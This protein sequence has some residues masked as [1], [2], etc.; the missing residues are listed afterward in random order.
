[1]TRPDAETETWLDIMPAIPLA[2]G[3]VVIVVHD[4]HPGRSFKAVCLHAS[5][6]EWSVHDG[7]SDGLVSEH[8]LRVDLDDPQGFGYALRFA[9]LAG[10]DDKGYL[11]RKPGKLPYLLRMWAQGTAD[12]ADRLDLARVLI[13]VTS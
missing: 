5:A 4:T 10:W 2:R 1:V 11:I 9:C 8:M 12:D 13:E 7:S 6:G 3:V